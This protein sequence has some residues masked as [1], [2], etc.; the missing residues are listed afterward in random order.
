MYCLAYCLCLYN[1]L[2]KTLRRPS[3]ILVFKTMYS[4]FRLK[5]A[6]H[7]CLGLLAMQLGL[8]A[9]N[10]LGTNV[11]STSP[12]NSEQVYTTP[13]YSSQ[14]EPIGWVKFGQGGTSAD[15]AGR[16]DI[17]HKV[18]EVYFTG[19]VEKMPAAS[20]GTIVPLSL[21]S[22]PTTG[23]TVLP[24]SSWWNPT[25]GESTPWI[26]NIQSDSSGVASVEFSMSGQRVGY[27]MIEILNHPVALINNESK[28]VSCS[29]LN[30][31]GILAST[32]L[33]NGG[34]ANY[35]A[36]PRSLL[37]TG[38]DVE[39]S[40]QGENAVVQVRLFQDSSSGSTDLDIDTEDGT[41]PG[42]SSLVL[43]N[44]TRARNSSIVNF[45]F[46]A[47]S[48]T[49]PLIPNPV[50]L[51]N[52][53]ISVRP[54]VPSSTPENNDN[55]CYSLSV[56]VDEWVVELRPPQIEVTFSDLTLNEEVKL[57][58][59]QTPY[60][61]STVTLLSRDCSVQLNTQNDISL[62]SASVSPLGELDVVWNINTDTIATNPSVYFTSEGESPSIEFCVRV[63][64]IVPS[65][66][67]SPL[68]VTQFDTV[69]QITLD[70][71]LNFNLV[72]GVVFR[73]DDPAV[74][75][76]NAFID[77]GVEACLCNT[78]TVLLGEL[79]DTV[80]LDSRLVTPNQ[81]VGICIQTDSNQVIIETLEELAF[82]QNNVNVNTPASQ[83]VNNGV[84]NPVTSIVTTNGLS[85]T[86]RLIAVSTRLLG[87]D[88]TQEVVAQG[89]A[90][91][92]FAD[93]RPSRRLQ[94]NVR[95][96]PNTSPNIIIESAQKEFEL[97]INVDGEL[98]VSEKPS[99]FIFPTEAYCAM[100]GAT[101]LAGA[102]FD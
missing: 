60:R 35:Y 15:L 50:E 42:D 90:T 57:Y 29:P 18:N 73:A 27:D 99:T 12:I 33:K 16:V 7:L 51:Y 92:A 71:T 87:V 68:V 75:T 44:T 82:Y 34:H 77:Y 85:P 86:G 58:Y 9:G 11:T 102:L 78:P 26:P 19:T 100:T 67:A 54:N 8:D 89:V 46:S 23:E 41:C 32:Q 40:N 43:D 74:V 94:L 96:T 49:T 4:L 63:S 61:N 70:L 25:L 101:V 22:C 65:S 81:P 39:L 14:Y 20:T 84:F 53:L 88:P 55:Q 76:Q 98:I 72:E 52:G 62:Y 6:L 80:A 79:C 83:P 36:N 3:C 38:F 30:S 5:Y 95:T 93:N 59:Y 69:V 48:Q 45:A 91:I 56:D 64:L 24:D 1:F 31:F 13:F 66:P 28:I 97:R 10:V 21:Y 17:L 47:L 2:L 37:I